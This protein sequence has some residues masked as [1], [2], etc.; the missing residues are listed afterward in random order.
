[1]CACVVLYSNNVW[2]LISF[3]F[4]S[5]AD[6]FM[7]SC[8][9]CRSSE[10]T[11]IVDTETKYYSPNA[12]CRLIGRQLC[13]ARVCWP[14]ALVYANKEVRINVQHTY[15]ARLRGTPRLRG[16]RLERHCINPAA[17]SD[18]VCPR[19]ADGELQK[20]RPRN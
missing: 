7:H 17:K 9:L 13:S 14:R 1:M 4:C 10:H 12:T 16:A 20:L 15:S 18:R 11:K 2:L 5:V 3:S 8:P 6:E 19:I